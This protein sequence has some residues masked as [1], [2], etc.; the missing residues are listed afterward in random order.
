MGAGFAKGKAQHAVAAEGHVL[1]HHPATGIGAAGREAAL[2]D[3]AELVLPGPA[4]ARR[5]LHLA[6]PRRQRAAVEVD[7][8]EGSGGGQRMGLARQAVQAGL[9]RLVAL[10][11]L[12]LTGR[13]RET[14]GAVAAS[15]IELDERLF[16]TVGRRDGHGVQARSAGGRIHVDPV[17]VQPGRARV[18]GE[19]GIEQGDRAAELQAAEGAADT[20][21]GLD[22]RLALVVLRHIAADRTDHIDAPAFQADMAGH[23]QCGRTQRRDVAAIGPLHVIAVD[24][25]SG[26]GFGEHNAAVV[27]DDAGNAR[28][29]GTELQCAEG[30]VAGCRTDQHH[31]GERRTITQRQRATLD[32]GQ[33]G[34]RVGTG[35]HQRA[36]AL[37]GQPTV[38]A[39]VVGPHRARCR[40]RNVDRDVA[41]VEPPRSIDGLGDVEQAVAEGAV[42]AGRAQVGGGAQQRLPHQVVAEIRVLLPDQRGGAGHQRR[43][44]GGAVVPEIARGTASG[45]CR[46]DVHR[47]A[48]GGQAISGGDAAGIGVGR[49]LAGTVG[50]DGG[51]AQ[52]AALQVGRRQ[53]AVRAGLAGQR[54]HAGRVRLAL[55]AGGEHHQAAVVEDEGAVFLGDRRGGRRVGPVQTAP[56]VVH[57][58]H[59]LVHQVRMDLGQAQR[60]VDFIA[61]AR[62]IVGGTLVGDDARRH[63]LRA[64]GDAAL[65]GAHGRTGG[66]FGHGG[67][68]PDHVIDVEVVHPRIDVGVVGQHAP[69]QRRMVAHHAG[70]DD[71]DAHAAAGQPGTARGAGLGDGQVRIEGRLRRCGGR[72]WRGGR[73]RGGRRGRGGIDA[74]IAA[75]TTPATRAQRRRERGDQYGSTHYCLV[76]PCFP[77]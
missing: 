34:I 32:A 1:A 12:Q 67:A 55:V 28:G 43:G 19:V 54:R 38:A 37:L 27:V 10:H 18:V 64:G 58:L 4:Q 51:D 73:G 9:Q 74:D 14:A 39:D 16:H 17:D 20:R 33:A 76:H 15:R 59:A 56:G 29:A 71:A 31:R 22:Q 40:L 66:Q 68:M 21:A 24:D 36:I 57:D 25:R 2:P 47:R 6:K 53:C 49:Q 23:L 46:I 7:A 65:P 42:H 48:R 45:K 75:P 72:G 77:N 70:I 69:G 8:V 30:A 60:A 5:A 3:L 63:D 52:P 44:E 50:I 41:P 61:A 26:I 11:L 35:Q 62:A 13:I